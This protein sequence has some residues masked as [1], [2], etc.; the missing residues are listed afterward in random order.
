TLPISTLTFGG[1][2]PN[3]TGS[4]PVLVTSATTVSVRAQG[5]SAADYP[6]ICHL[7]TLACPPNAP[8]TSVFYR[9]YPA[10]SVP[11]PFTMVSG[12]AAS[13][14]LSG[15]VGSYEIDYYAV[16]GLGSLEPMHHQMVL[17]SAS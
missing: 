2:P 13:L 7:L 17:L 5:A 16:G 10:G 1:V 8:K 12:A 14:N 3:A 9:V 15:L 4:I 6:R 11:P